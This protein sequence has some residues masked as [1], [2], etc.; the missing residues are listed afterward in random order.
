MH[1]TVLALV[2]QRKEGLSVGMGSFEFWGEILRPYSQGSKK[3]LQ[4]MEQVSDTMEERVGRATG[5]AE[6]F[7]GPLNR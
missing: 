1:P 3:P 5:R 2:G 4:F 6:L 7:L